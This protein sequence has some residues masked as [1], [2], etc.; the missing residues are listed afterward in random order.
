MDAIP[1]KEYKRCVTAVSRCASQLLSSTPDPFIPGLGI[2][3]SHDYTPA[4]A[5]GE[6]DTIDDQ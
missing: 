4:T 2:F 1:P 5:F 3:R 6:M